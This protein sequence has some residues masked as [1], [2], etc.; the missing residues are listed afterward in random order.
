VAPFTDL[1][2]LA[3]RC[4]SNA[5]PTILG[6]YPICYC[7]PVIGYFPLVDGVGDWN[8]QHDP[9]RLDA[10]ERNMAIKLVGMDIRYAALP[11]HPP[12]HG[13][14]TLHG[15]HGEP[16]LGLGPAV[17]H[18]REPREGADR[19][20][21]WDYHQG[22]PDTPGIGHLMP[23]HSRGSHYAGGEC[24]FIGTPQEVGT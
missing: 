10:Y 8:D 1:Y 22:E 5:T 14:A 2:V 20:V 3:R 6:Q 4:S 11:P 21:I 12:Q 15:E 19:A 13:P 7:L 17:W 16:V 18:L 24:M 23:R 9:K